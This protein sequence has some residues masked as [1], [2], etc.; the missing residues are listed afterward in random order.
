MNRETAITALALYTSLKALYEARR[1]IES[2]TSSATMTTYNSGGSKLV[3]VDRDVATQMLT[4]TI[5]AKEAELTA[6]GFEP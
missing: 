6:L 5:N 3:S 2:P 4:A 1:I